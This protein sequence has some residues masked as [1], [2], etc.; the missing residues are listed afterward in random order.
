V[1]VKIRRA[2]LQDAAAI[3]SLY[4]QLKEHHARLAPDSP[5]YARNDEGWVGYME[6][7]LNDPENW[8]YV[9]LRGSDV[10][11]FVRFFFD[12][13]S[14]GRACEVE[15][16]VVNADA[17]ANGVGSELM[18]KVEQIARDEGALAM[19]VNVLHTNADGR[20]FYERSGYRPLAI[21]YAK[22]L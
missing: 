4:M 21:R 14:W 3:A 19:R 11:G 22:P 2:T 6:R 17:R 18:R 9:A 12:E 1:H 13:R 20:K 15:T 8:F 5:F 10:V 16:L 7:G